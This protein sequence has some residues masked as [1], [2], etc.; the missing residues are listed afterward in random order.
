MYKRINISQEDLEKAQDAGYLSQ[1][2]HRTQQRPYVSEETGPQTEAT[3]GHCYVRKKCFEAEA[4]EEARQQ[5]PR[6][7]RRI[8]WSPIQRCETECPNDGYG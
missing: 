6:Q 7:R 3:T 1:R 2:R 8:P 5:C 4:A